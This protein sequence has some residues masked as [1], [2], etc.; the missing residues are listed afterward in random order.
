MNR[1]KILGVVLL[2][3]GFAM[4]LFSVYIMNEVGEGR[5]KISTSQSVVD[6]GKGLFSENPFG[7]A[8]TDSAQEKLDEGSEE[9]SAYE[10]LAHVL[11]IGGAILIVVGAGVFILGFI[12]RNRR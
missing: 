8:A 7:K 11:H 4:Y 1:K 10:K 2:V 9:A 12:N 6:A 3:V 5:D